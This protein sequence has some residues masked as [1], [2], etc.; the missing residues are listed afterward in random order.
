M[1]PKSVIGHTQRGGSSAPLKKLTIRPLKSRPKLPDN[2]E[3]VTW[4][5]LQ[6]AVRAVHA[7]EAVGTSL[8]ELYRA[9]ENMCVQNLAATVYERLQAECEAKIGER[10]EALLGQ[11]PDTLA[12][13]ALVQTCWT[14]HC[15]QMHMLRSIFLFLDRTYVMQARTHAPRAARRGGLVS[16]VPTASRP[17]AD[18]V[19]EV[20]VGHGA[21]AVPGP[22]RPPAG[23]DAE[24]RA[25]PAGA[26]LGQDH[27]GY[28][29]WTSAFLAFPL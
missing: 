4:A 25:G 6:A 8:E 24:D 13:L 9:V 19:E 20:A 22:P 26:H 10:L 3:Q 5:R 14:D 23:G 27:V 12:F 1:D 7:K 18:L 17:P 28:V 15:E 29:R 2:F 11:T 16:R 21:A